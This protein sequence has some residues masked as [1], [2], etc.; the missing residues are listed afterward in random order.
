MPGDDDDQMTQREEITTHRSQSVTTKTERSTFQQVRYETRHHAAAKKK[1]T[2]QK[3]LFESV[4][5]VQN[6]GSP[7]PPRGKKYQ[8]HQNSKTK[9]FIKEQRNKMSATLEPLPIGANARANNLQD[10]A[11]VT[12]YQPAAG[13]SEHNTD[14]SVAVMAEGDHAGAKQ[15]KLHA[16][17]VV[18]AEVS[19]KAGYHSPAYGKAGKVETVN[20]NAV[21]D[22][23][24]SMKNNPAANKAEE[25]AKLVDKDKKHLRK[26]F[27]NKQESVFTAPDGHE[28]N[29]HATV[30]K[31]LG[32]AGYQIKVNKNGEFKLKEEQPQYYESLYHFANRMCDSTDVSPVARSNANAMRTA[33]DHRYKRRGLFTDNNKNT[34]LNVKD[35]ICAK[36]G[37]LNYGLDVIDFDKNYERNTNFLKTDPMPQLAFGGHIFELVRRQD[38]SASYQTNWTQSWSQ[39]QHTLPADETLVI[40]KI[41]NYEYVLRPQSAERHAVDPDSG[42]SEGTGRPY[43]NYVIAGEKHKLRFNYGDHTEADAMDRRRKEVFNQWNPFYGKYYPKKLPPMHSVKRYLGFL[44]TKSV[45]EV[46]YKQY[47]LDKYNGFASCEELFGPGGLF[48]QDMSPKHNITASSLSTQEDD[49]K[50]EGA[51]ILEKAISEGRLAEINFA[52]EMAKAA[53]RKAAEH[54]QYEKRRVVDVLTEK[55][56]AEVHAD[57]HSYIRAEVKAAVDK[58]DKSRYRDLFRIEPQAMEEGFM[59][60]DGS[61]VYSSLEEVL[62]TIVVDEAR[63]GVL[64]VRNGGCEVSESRRCESHK[65][66]MD[67]PVE[68][69]I[70]RDYLSNQLAFAA[71]EKMDFYRHLSRKLLK[72]RMLMHRLNKFYDSPEELGVEHCKVLQEIVDKGVT[73]E[74]EEEDDDYKTAHHLHNRVTGKLD[75]EMSLAQKVK[76]TI[77]E[78][79][80]KAAHQKGERKQYFELTQKQIERAE[81]FHAGKKITS[82]VTKTT[83]TTTTTTTT[84]TTKK[85]QT[86]DKNGK[87][88]QEDISKTRKNSV[89]GRRSSLIEARVREEAA[90][91]REQQKSSAF[92]KYVRSNAPLNMEPHELRRLNIADAFRQVLISKCGNVRHAYYALKECTSGNAAVKPREGQ[93][94]KKMKGKNAGLSQVQVRYKINK[95]MEEWIKKQ[96]NKPG[97]YQKNGI[98]YNRRKDR[99]LIEQAEAKVKAKEERARKKKEAEEA[100]AKKKKM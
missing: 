50:D 64:K 69:Y 5:L 45:S 26:I 79:H 78:A 82:E 22:I 83:K 43:R 20:H 100:S 1:V 76:H 77:K 95:L 27:L 29:K 49:C 91:E 81:K 66:I 86:L 75:K 70:V 80:K 4:G 30:V 93:E 58:I 63:P 18:T 88:V 90:R 6:R 46:M 15:S 85:T 48:M 35:E 73:E 55:E 74:D 60:F 40:Q 17:S 12:L 16:F 32:Q 61:A 10:Q 31:L 71:I 47:L 2:Q 36:H 56:S 9:K 11:S 41:G 92:E 39:A 52:A 89:E 7:S 84:E 59:A 96:A 34:V 94:P 13:V 87:V 25:E 28:V 44:Y 21:G 99:E 19:P 57:A 38:A 8:T 54:A 33:P 3:P 67:Q 51:K 65:A 97:R 42:R 24:T 23:T 53:K 62:C 14:N 98:E 72:G 68:S 37:R